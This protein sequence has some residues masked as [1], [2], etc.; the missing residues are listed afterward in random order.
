MRIR[1][2]SLDTPESVEG[3][4]RSIAML[5]PQAPVWDREDACEVL[6]RL[7]EVLRQLRG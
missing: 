7:G 5:P 4:R 6:E 2:G 3:L 1:A